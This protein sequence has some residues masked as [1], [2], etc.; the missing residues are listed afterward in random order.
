MGRTRGVSDKGP[1]VAKYKR[2]E[3]LNDGI[4]NREIHGEICGPL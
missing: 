2:S 3:V 1:S 4:E